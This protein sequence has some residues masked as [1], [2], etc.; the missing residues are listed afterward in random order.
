VGEKQF[1]KLQ[2]GAIVDID[3]IKHPQGEELVYLKFRSDVELDY[4]EDIC[5]KKPGDFPSHMVILKAGSV[6]VF[7]TIA[8]NKAADSQVFQIIGSWQLYRDDDLPEGPTPKET[9]DF[10]ANGKLLV[11]GDHPNKGLYRINGNQLEFLIK[12]GGRALIAKRQF[13]LSAEELRFKNDKIGWVYYKRVSEQ[14]K[15]E[16][17]DLR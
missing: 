11:S 14:P 6:L 4:K 15:G 16:E 3:V 13:E 7:P 9:L 8:P 5:C 17:P 10:W 12:K 1:R 2:G